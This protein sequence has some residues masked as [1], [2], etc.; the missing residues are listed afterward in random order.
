MDIGR[1]AGN[2]N[3]L[4]RQAILGEQTAV[5]ANV[6]EARLETDRSLTDAYLFLAAG[7]PQ[8]TKHQQ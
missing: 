3:N 2:V 7:I 8:Q 1:A 6:H 5:L 4:R